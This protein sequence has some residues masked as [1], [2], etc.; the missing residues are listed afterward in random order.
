MYP[1]G[2]NAGCMAQREK[3]QLERIARIVSWASD[4]MMKLLPAIL[5]RVLL[6]AACLGQCTGLATHVTLRS[7]QHFTAQ[8]LIHFLAS[9][10][11]LDVKEE[12]QPFGESDPEHPKEIGFNAHFTDIELRYPLSWAL[13]FTLQ[14]T[15]TQQSAA[16]RPRAPQ[17]GHSEGAR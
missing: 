11:G 3:F 8:G 10:A 1:A 13:H 12:S 2:A 7:F 14:N 6:P 4:R 16:R 5:I 15:S 17:S 9:Q